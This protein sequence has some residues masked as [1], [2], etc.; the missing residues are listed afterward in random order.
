MISEKTELDTDLIQNNGCVLWM[1]L[2]FMLNLTI[3]RRIR[4]IE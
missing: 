3:F 2:N 1:F 4:K